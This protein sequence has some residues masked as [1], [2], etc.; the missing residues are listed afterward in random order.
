MKIPSTSKYEFDGEGNALTSKYKFDGEGNALPYYGNDTLS[1]QRDTR[2]L[3]TEGII[4]F[5]NRESDSIY[6]TV[7]HVQEEMKKTG[8]SHCLAFLPPSSFHMTVLSLCRELDRGSA[9]WPPFIPK[10][11]RFPEIDRILKEKVETVPF[12]NDIVMIFDGCDIGKVTLRPYDERSEKLL[13][14]YRDQVSSLVEVR[15]PGHDDFRFYIG[16]DYGIA[17]LS[18]NEW[19]ECSIFCMQ[20]TEKLRKTEKPFSILKPHYVIFNDMLSYETVLSKKGPLY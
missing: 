18:E 6:Q 1:G 2:P 4:S 16:I 19:E 5:L 15:Y 17:Q 10:D 11:M 12:P 14:G 13:R 8:F 9:Y 7:C 3:F 20:M